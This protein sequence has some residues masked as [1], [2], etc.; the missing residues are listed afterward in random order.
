MSL[1]AELYVLA[2]A[3]TFMCDW[4]GTDQYLVLKSGK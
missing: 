1:S 2:P 3:P 4:A